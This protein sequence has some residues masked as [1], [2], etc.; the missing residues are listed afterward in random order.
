MNFFPAEIMGQGTEKP[1]TTLGVRPHDVKI[2]S[3][4]TG[5]LDAWVEVVEP[6]GSELLVYLRLG[7]NRD[8]AVVRVIAPP[9]PAIEEERL[10]GVVFDRARLHW[11]EAESGQRL[12]G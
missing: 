8:G 12:S 3:Q 11:F 10:V 9:E 1:G 6:L 7:A 4:G 2:V 5:D